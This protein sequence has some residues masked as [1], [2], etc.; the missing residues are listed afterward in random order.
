MQNISAVHNKV[1]AVS[2]LKGAESLELKK[3]WDLRFSANKSVFIEAE[4][5]DPFLKIMEVLREKMQKQNVQIANQP[6]ILAFFLDLRCEIPE[7]L[8]TI[9][10]GIETALKCKLHLVMQFGYVGTKS[11]ENPTVQRANACRLVEENAQVLAIQQR[12]CLVASPYYNINGDYSWKAVCVYLDV[13]SRQDN[14]SKLIPDA[15]NQSAGYLRYGE[16][17]QHKY[18]A[19]NKRKAELQATL[20]DGGTEKF[21]ELLTLKIQ[22]LS[23]VDVQIN[24]AA[25]PLHPNMELEGGLFQYQWKKAKSGG[26]RDFNAAQESSQAAVLQTADHLRQSIAR[27][28]AQSVD[29]AQWILEQLMEEASLGYKLR[30][31]QNRMCSLLQNTAQPVQM[32]SRVELPFNEHGYS[33]EID[34]YLQRTKEFEISCQVQAFWDALKDSYFKLLENGFREEIAQWEEELEDIQEQLDGMLQL[35]GFFQEYYLKNMEM[36]ESEFSPATGNCPDKKFLVCST[37]NAAVVTTEKTGLPV[38]F[39]KQEP[40]TAGLKGIQ[41]FSLMCPSPSTDILKLL[42]E[43][44]L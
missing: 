20:A 37:E 19:L 17:D 9:K 41:V 3:Q 5:G 29:R 8:Q 24:A 42:P 43:V 38:I 10:Q 39:E 16:C 11:L 28:F 1:L 6:C 15:G 31:D 44:T 18:D 23:S 12:L 30:Q 27:I 2:Y 33:E 26:H 25:Q 35:D 40:D 36:P 34:I 22:Q 4:T 14:I 32:P 21:Q 7:K 13:L